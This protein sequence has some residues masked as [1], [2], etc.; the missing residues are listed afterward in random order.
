MD[1][2]HIK[3]DEKQTVFLLMATFFYERSLRQ[4]LPNKDIRFN[5]RD[6][7]KSLEADEYE[8]T[9]F[10]PQKMKVVLN[11]PNEIKEKSMN[12]PYCP[13]K[14]KANV[15]KFAEHMLLMMPSYYWPQNETNKG[16]EQ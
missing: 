11:Y 13:R 6:L 3:S 5:L 16:L 8:E 15:E 9:D 4:P 2:R 14:K 1:D 10:F 12:F 7:K